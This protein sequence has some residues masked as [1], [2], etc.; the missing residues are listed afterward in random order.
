MTGAAVAGPW[1]L[2]TLWAI[3]A[4]GLAGGFGHCI[5]MCGPLL[6][7]SGLVSGATAGAGARRGARVRAIAL[8]QAAYHGG[9]LLTYS[10]LGALLGALGSLAAVRGMLGPVQRWVWLIAGVLMIVMGLAVAGAPW[11]R[12]LGGSLES[13]AGLA[14]GAWYAKAFRTL[15]ARGP[16][17]AFPL[18]MLN[19]LLPCGF[20]ASIAVSALAAG[21][22]VLG[23]ATMLAFGLGTV[24]ALAG[25]GAASGL[26]GA[27]PRAW[28]LRLGGAIVVV[29]GVLYVVRA[30]GMLAS[31][32]G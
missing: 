29:L 16:W 8:W 1:S 32:G 24:P 2:A 22:P 18:G 7:A 5:G 9:R 4:V 25:F 30:A 10:C 17:A 27:Q 28:L 6:A 21:S 3:F 12:R 31:A 11:L 19:G 15:Q 14:S 26:L 13:G 23:A 20:L